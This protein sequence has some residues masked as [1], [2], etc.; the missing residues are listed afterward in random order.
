MYNYAKIV[1]KNNNE[2]TII[3]PKIFGSYEEKSKIKI[4]ANIYTTSYV[5]KDNILELST[6]SNIPS[7]IIYSKDENNNYILEEYTEARDGSEF[8]SSI[9]E[10]CT[11]PVS[12]EPINGLADEIINQYSDNEYFQTLERKNLIKYLKANKMEG[13]SLLDTSSYEEEKLIPLTDK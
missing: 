12:Q 7:A 8:S 4:F 13:V 10:F 3:S 6:G 5:M 2:F 9:K 11:M 1:N